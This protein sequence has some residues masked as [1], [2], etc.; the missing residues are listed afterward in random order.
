M[1]SR[2][3]PPKLSWHC[4]WPFEIKSLKRPLLEPR[5]TI[6]PHVFWNASDVR[7]LAFDEASQKLAEH[8]SWTRPDVEALREHEPNLI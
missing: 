6:A 4:Y 8:D 5:K 1:L 2:D 7:Q 3:V